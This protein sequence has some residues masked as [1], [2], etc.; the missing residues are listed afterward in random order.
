MFSLL[1][2]NLPATGRVLFRGFIPP[3]FESIAWATG[4]R[5]ELR[6]ATPEFVWCA[7]VDH[8]SWGSADVCAFRQGQPAL[9]FIEFAHSLTDAEKADALMGQATIG[10]KLRSST[11]NVLQDR[12]RLLRWL[13]AL[14]GDDG[15]IAIDDGSLLPWSHAMLDD[16]LVHDAPLDVEALYTLHA[17]SAGEGGRVTWLHTHGLAE[18]GAFDFDI[19]EPSERFMLGCADPC[20]SL[21]CAGLEGLARPGDAKYQLAYPDG[22]VRLVPVTEF[23]AK[24]AADHRALRDEDEP[25]SGN[26]VVICDAGGWFASWRTAPTPS[27]FLATTDAD[28]VVFPFSEGATA[29]GAERAR[30]TVPVLRALGSEFADLGLPM[31]LKLGYETDSGSREHLWFEC[32]ALHDDHADATLVNA[33]F[34]IAAM[35]EGDRGTHSYERLSDW[36]ILSPAGSMTPRNISAAR[37]VREHRDE[38]AAAL[39]ARQ[40]P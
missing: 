21:A 22:I 38:I 25:H 2:R 6:D 19:L 30:Q 18:V 31:L 27:R 9:P 26:R 8:P 36:Q 33:P 4:V 35:K 40:E 14:L 20:R 34:D 28:R 5:V 23:M 1:R 37:V 11:G 24:A 7:E 12:K 32:H 10:V 39:R 17:V 16:E 15:V 29:L 3:P 13:R